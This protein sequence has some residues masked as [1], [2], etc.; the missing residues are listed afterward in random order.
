MQPTTALGL[1]C[2]LYFNIVT[3]SACKVVV[4]LN[5][6]Y[7]CLS[8]R[9]IDDTDFVILSPIRRSL[10]GRCPDQSVVV[11]YVSVR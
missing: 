1:L 5:C 4:E 2:R 9:L 3:S 11:H 6:I 8:D 7:E 10:L